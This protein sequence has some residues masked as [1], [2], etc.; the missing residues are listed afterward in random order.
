MGSHSYGISF[1]STYIWDH[2]HMGSH[3]YGITFISTYSL[4]HLECHFFNHMGSHSYRITFIW[5]LIHMGSHSYQRTYGIT[6][7]WDHIHMGSHSY[8]RAAYCI[9]SVISSQSPFSIN[10]LVFE[11]SF[12]TFRWKETKEIEIED[13]DEMTL[14]MQLAV[15]GT[16]N[17]RKSLWGGYA[18]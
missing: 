4:L 6:F 9:W 3:S 2:I 7:I 16:P 11:V 18:Q 5:D 8:Q 1:I 13:W 15:H 14:P 10:H 12:T 17:T